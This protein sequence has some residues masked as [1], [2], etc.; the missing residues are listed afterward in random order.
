MGLSK[1][2]NALLL[3]VSF[4]L[5]RLTGRAIHAGMPM[6]ISVEPT[7]ACNLRCPECPSGLRS[8]TRPTGMMQP[9]FFMRL[10]DQ[11]QGT[12]V[13]INFYFQGEP[14][15]NKDLPGM[16]REASR[17]RIFTS[18]STNGHFI[19][20]DTAME[21]V[22]SGLHRLIVSI[23]GTTQ[24]VYEQY[25]VGGS[26]EKALQGA[27][28][29]IRIKQELRSKFP[30]VILQFLVVRPNEHQI[31]DVLQ[32]GKEL[33][34]QE[35]RLKT[36]QVYDFENGNS[37]IPEQEKYARYRRMANGKWRLKNKLSNHCWRM[38]QGC[39]FTWDGR[40]LPCCFDKDG[41]FSLGD[42]TEQTFLRA[43]KGKKYRHFR[44]TV[45]SGRD[46]LEICKNCTE[47]T[48]VWA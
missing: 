44:Q 45:F 29:I 9:G 41:S 36:A 39:V 16:I 28:N 32:L 8:F 23:D 14:F 13:A 31:E 15:L 24:D 20:E 47:G 19:D 4:Y 21:T 17:R 48:K 11:L 10:L 43:W 1:A 40:I 38:W 2:T 12:L 25:R 30:E 33:G 3:S 46:Q 37:L 26:L 34:V 22:K 35:V 6:S 7:T 18:T 27:R 42:L 5:S